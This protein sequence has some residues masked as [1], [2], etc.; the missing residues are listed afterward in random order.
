MSDTINVKEI[1]AEKIILSHPDSKGS[2]TLQ[3]SSSGLLGIWLSGADAK[4]QIAVYSMKGQ[5]CV[6]VYDGD[7]SE[8]GIDVGIAV[9][10]GEA[11]LQLVDSKGK[12]VQLS[13][14]QARDLKN[15]LPEG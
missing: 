11:F 8:Q 6:G 7:H 9:H 12:V 5:T 13:A 4:N 1:H 10:N 3:A 14:D 2:I 15:L